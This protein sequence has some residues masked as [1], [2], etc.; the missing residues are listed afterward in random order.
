HRPSS[1]G[2]VSL[3]PFDGTRCAESAC[4]VARIDTRRYD[5]V[6]RRSETGLL[7]PARRRTGIERRGGK[8][9]K[10]ETLSLREDELHPPLSE[11]QPLMHR[12]RL[13]RRAQRAGHSGHQPGHHQR[14]DHDED[15]QLDQAH[16]AAGAPRKAAPAEARKRAHCTLALP[17]TGLTTTVRGPP[18]AVSVIVASLAGAARLLGCP[19]VSNSR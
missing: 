7:R 11:L 12:P 13:G 15:E 3:P 19:L 10:T 4:R 1:E 14:R 17:V 2:R 8:P 6:L 9:R 5:R 18:V 16:A